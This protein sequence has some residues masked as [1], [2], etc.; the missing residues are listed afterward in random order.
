[1]MEWFYRNKISKSKEKRRQQ[2][3]Q[4]PRRDGHGRRSFTNE[5]PE[6]IRSRGKTSIADN[7]NCVRH[8]HRRRRLCTITQLSSYISPKLCS[9]I[10]WLLLN[11]SE[12]YTDFFVSYHLQSWCA[13][14]L[15]A[16]N[17]TQWSSLQPSCPIRSSAYHDGHRQHILRISGWKPFSILRSRPF[18]I[19]SFSW[20]HYHI[21]SFLCLERGGEVWNLKGRINKIYFGAMEATKI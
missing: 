14:S 15:L 5:Y 9:S 3:Q 13:F 20:Y 19:E 11:G 16:N 2:S 4:I 7:E 12:D 6:T 8:R 18:V 10:S 1:M 17:P 21:S